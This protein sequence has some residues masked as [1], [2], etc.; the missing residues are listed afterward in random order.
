MYAA[1]AQRTV[2]LATLRAIGFKPFSVVIALISECLLLACGGAVIGA[3][4]AWLLFNGNLMSM[5]AGGDALGASQVAFEMRIHGDLLLTAIIWACC[6][7]LL[8]AL[9]PAVRAA[10][11]PIVN[12]LAAV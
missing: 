12:G 8:G 3:A 9:T 5:M 4:V 7:G 2:E 10:R 11:M 1:V 6:I